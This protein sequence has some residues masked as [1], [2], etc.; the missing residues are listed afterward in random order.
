MIVDKK[1]HIAKT[2]SYRVVSSMIGFVI[3]WYTSG[4][5]EIGAT[6]T[7]AELIYKPFLYYLHERFYYK[8]VKFGVKKDVSEK[9]N[10]QLP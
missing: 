9:N 10:T 5:V 2:I 6:F 4:S 3:I 1:R 7:T 8:F